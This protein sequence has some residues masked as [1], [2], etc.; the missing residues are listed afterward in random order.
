MN[1]KEFMSGKLNSIWNIY[2]DDFKL[3][4]WILTY[5][6]KN[7]SNKEIVNLCKKSRKVK[8]NVS[9]LIP[10]IIRYS[11]GLIGNEKSKNR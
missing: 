3:S 6:K 1:Y 9:F 11:E 10:A 7:I 2:F 4:D 5:G 8:Q